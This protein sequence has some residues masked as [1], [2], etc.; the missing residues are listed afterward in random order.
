MYHKKDKNYYVVRNASCPHYRYTFK[1]SL[2]FLINESMNEL[3]NQQSIS[4]TAHPPSIT[5]KTSFR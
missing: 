3:I 5:L 1:L 2:I 4:R